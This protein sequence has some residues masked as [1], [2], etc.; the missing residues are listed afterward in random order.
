MFVGY[1]TVIGTV[2]ALRLQA[3]PD[4]KMSSYF[5][6]HSETTGRIVTKC[7]LP[8]NNYLPSNLEVAQNAD[9]RDLTQA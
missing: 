8:I 4:P 6:G 1:T 2:I 9:S 7:A 5:L 3:S